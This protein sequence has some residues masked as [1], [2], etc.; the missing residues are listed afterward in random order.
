MDTETGQV[1]LLR[2]TSVHDAGRVLNPQGHEGQ[3]RGGAMQGIGYGLME[4]LP[5]REGRVSTPSFADYK[6]PNIAD[7]PQMQAIAIESEGG[8]GPFNVKAIGENPISP[9]APAIANA[10][11]DAVGV[12]IRDLPITA[13]KVYA[14]L[15]AKGG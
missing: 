7:I 10:I 12:R 14:A 6:V 4:E 2:F 5:I 3:I 1:R 9:V 15:R 8:V 11:E 13:E